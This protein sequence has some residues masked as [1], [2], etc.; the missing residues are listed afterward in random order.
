MKEP[1]IRQASRSVIGHLSRRNLL[2]GLVGS[3]GTV[4]TLPWLSRRAI[5]S[6]DPAAQLRELGI[7]LPE[8]PPPVAN[9]VPY[10]I[11]GNQVFLAGQIA[12]QDGELLFPGKVGVNVSV[13]D[14]AAAARQVAINL[15]AALNA[16]C[17]GD[18]SRVVRCVRLDGFVASADDFTAQPSVMNGASDLMVEVFGDAGRH[19]RA[20]IGV[21]VLPLDASVEISAV[22]EIA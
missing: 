16:A 11:T 3:I 15:I 18:L 17:E 12:F 7:E 5:A 4:A 20:A 2:W 8:V 19:S 1:I 10:V 9:Y 14:G 6:T 22:F 21:N 13:E